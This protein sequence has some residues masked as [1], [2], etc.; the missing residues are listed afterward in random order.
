MPRV[1]ADGTVNQIQHIVFIVKENRSFENYLGTYPGANAAT[2]GKFSTGQV[3]PLGHTADGLK[4]DICHSWNCAHTAIDNGLMDKF[5][6]ATGS[7]ANGFIAMSQ[8]T[9]NDLP[10]Y[11]SYA[12]HFVLADNMFSSLT[13]PSLP[14][15]LF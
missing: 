7:V 9:Q 4:T 8:Y 6:S 13:G 2:S 3:L 5:D 10:N 14:N 1:Y 11:W 15:H 12:Q